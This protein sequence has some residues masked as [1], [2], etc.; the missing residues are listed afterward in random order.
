MRLTG[1][2]LAFEANGDNEEQV[3][4]ELVCCCWGLHL[5]WFV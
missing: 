3:V 2:L 1:E 5:G 4:V